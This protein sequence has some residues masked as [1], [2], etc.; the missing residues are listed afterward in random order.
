M[1]K[2][3]FTCFQI[4]MPTMNKNGPDTQL[5]WKLT[6]SPIQCEYLDP[7]AMHFSDRL[8]NRIGLAIGN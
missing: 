6:Y 3:V 4:L 8:C 1:A 7:S 5:I 2:S